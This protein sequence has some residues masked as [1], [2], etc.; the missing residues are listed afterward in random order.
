MYFNFNK[1]IVW[2]WIGRACALQSSSEHEDPWMEACQSQNPHLEI[3]TRDVAIIGGG[4]TGTFAAIKLRDENRTVSVIE[5]KGRLGG[6]TETY[7]DPTTGTPID[8]GVVVLH[9]LDIVHEYFNRLSVPLSKVPLSSGGLTDYFDFTTGT[10]SNYTPPDP[11][12]A[13]EA[14]TAQLAKYPYLEEGFDLPEN[15]PEDL[16]LPFGTFTRKYNLDNV[17]MTAYQIAQGYGDFLQLPTIYVMKAFGLSL[18]QEIPTGLLASLRGNNSEIYGRAQAELGSDVHLHSTVL[19]TSRDHLS[20]TGHSARILI[21]TPT[22]RKLIKAKQLLITIP[23]TL[24][25]LQPFDLDAREHALFSQFRYSSYY[26]GILN[27]TGLPANV[28]IANAD[29]DRPFALPALPAAYGFAATRVPGLTDLKYGSTSNLSADAVKT[30]TL[31]T[32]R[33]LRDGGDLDFEIPSDAQPSFV[34]F[35]GHTPFAMRVEAEAIRAGFYRELG[36]LQGRRNVWWTGAAWHT[37]D[38]GLLW[39]FTAKVVDRLVE[40]L[41]SA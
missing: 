19:S 27:Q 14:Y 11:S 30:N 31:A 2:L 12:S 37:H 6:H 4:S 35:S 22:G 28:S 7:T 5:Q 20:R 41:E 9:D 39:R 25:N 15:I 21:Q 33:R 29:T 3:I 38:S 24:A 23:P 13:L 16:L 8:Y 1:A 36:A 40:A 26:T 32:L 34:A 18:I 10:R 17:V